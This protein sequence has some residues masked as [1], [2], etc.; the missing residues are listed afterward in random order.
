MQDLPFEDNGPSA[1]ADAPE[2]PNT[3]LSRLLRQS[4]LYPSWNVCKADV[5]CRLQQQ[6]ILENFHVHNS[7]SV[8][9]FPATMSAV[10]RNLDNAARSREEN[11]EGACRDMALDIVASDTG[12]SVSS[13]TIDTVHETRQNVLRV[14]CQI[15]RQ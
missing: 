10:Q 11:C 5:P 6:G 4:F 13:E 3:C 14:A 9:Q 8:R 7:S 15:Q 2:I 1:L 12:G